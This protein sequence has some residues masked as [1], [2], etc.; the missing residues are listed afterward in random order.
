MTSVYPG[1]CFTAHQLFQKA[2]QRFADRKCMGTREFLGWHTPEGQKYP[3]KIFGDSSWQTYGEISERV[4][5]FGAGLVALGM[6]PMPLDMAK[7]VVGDFA[8][9]KGPHCLLVFEETCADWMTAAMGAMSMSMPV[10]TSYATLGMSSVAEAIQQTNA[11]VIL[12]NYSAVEKVR[13]F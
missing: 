6:K 12:C 3:V 10:A 11:P 13:L 9:I 1:E 8:A 2:F 4:Q 7:S 5:A